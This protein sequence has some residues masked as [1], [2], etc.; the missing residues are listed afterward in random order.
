MK[1]AA[2]A[3]QPRAPADNQGY[4][5]VQREQHNLL[6]SPRIA[7]ERLDILGLLALELQQHAS[8]VGSTR[9][10]QAFHLQTPDPCIIAGPDPD[11]SVSFWSHRIVQLVE[12]DV[13]T[14]LNGR[15][16][17]LLDFSDILKACRG[18]E[19][20]GL[21]RPLVMKFSRSASS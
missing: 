8:L 7:H 10:T 3:V 11:P 21:P 1:R 4:R 15:N 12:G 16:A 17:R 18:P 6:A 14:H 13:L 5:R 9:D 20:G 19:R 2:N